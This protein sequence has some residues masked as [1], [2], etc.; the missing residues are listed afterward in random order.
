[1][2]GAN[3][4][5]AG[6]GILLLLLALNGCGGC[7]SGVAS[8]PAGVY[9]CPGSADHIIVENDEIAFFIEL[10]PNRPR[11][12]VGSMTYGYEVMPDGRVRFV[13]TSTEAAYGLGRFD[14]S[15]NGSEI[16]MQEVRGSR[17][18]VFSRAD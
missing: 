11:E 8:I 15:W 3:T 5:E 6:A 17:R 7:A 12:G 14:F 2:P 4:R 9:R 18:C 10:Q 16:V 13:V 1:M